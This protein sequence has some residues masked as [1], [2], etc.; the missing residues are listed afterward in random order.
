MLSFKDNKLIPLPETDL[1]TNDLLERVNLQEAIVNSWEAFTKEISSPDLYLIG[2]EVIPD[3]RVNDRIDILAFDPN[4]NILVVFEL[5]RDKNK[6]QLLQGITYAAMLASWD[7]DR[8]IAE[9]RKQK[10]P[11]LEDIESSLSGIQLEQNVRIILVAEK[12]DPEVIVSADWLYKQF[13]MD[14]SAM[15]LSL[16]K[17]KDELYFSFQQRYP[18]PELNDTYELRGKKKSQQSTVS[19]KTWEEVAE[20][21]KYDWGKELLEKCRREKEG[22]PSRKRILRFRTNYDGLNWITVSFK[23]NFVN[24]YMGGKPENVEELLQSKFKDKIEVNSW[25]D[26]HSFHI[27]T[28]SQYVDLCKWLEIKE[29]PIKRVA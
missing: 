23:I 15:S 7:S 20:T 10:S 2:Q 27:T 5:K 25:R 1:K 16:F 3:D 24:V 4:D 11:D 8:L 9:A 21:F 14:I 22:D 18:L 28:R 17:R 6:L 26:G 12:F 29:I 19:E 13:N